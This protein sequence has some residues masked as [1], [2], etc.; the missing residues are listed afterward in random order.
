MIISTA[1]QGQFMFGTGLRLADPFFNGCFILIESLNSFQLFE[2]F[3]CFSNVLTRVA[4]FADTGLP[5]Q[6]LTDFFDI[7]TFLFQRNSRKEDAPRSNTHG[8]LHSSSRSRER[9][10]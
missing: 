8:N 7:I 5:F 1:I 10:C 3:L 4:N 2:R 9:V 6:V